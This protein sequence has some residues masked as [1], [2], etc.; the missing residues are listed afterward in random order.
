[1]INRKLNLQPVKRRHHRRHM[2]GYTL[3]E[4][5]IVIAILGLLAA[6]VGPRLITYLGRAKTD[7]ARLQLDQIA[8]SLDLYH[9][10]VGQYPAQQ[11]GLAA[12]IAAPSGAKSWAGPYLKKVETL[13]DPWGNPVR[14]VSPGQHGDYD[15]YSLGAD[16]A[17]GGEGENA[18]VTSWSSGQQ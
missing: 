16:N 17:E 14:Y 12:L 9:L 10:D 8:T 3:L 15:L 18:D 7:T 11:D 4:L 6:V 2:R 13:K 5:L 1:M